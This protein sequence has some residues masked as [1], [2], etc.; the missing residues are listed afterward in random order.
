MESPVDSENITTPLWKILK[1]LRNTFSFLVTFFFLSF[2]LLFSQGWHFILLNKKIP[3]L[4]LTSTKYS[5][6]YNPEATSC[7]TC[8]SLLDKLCE[9]LQIC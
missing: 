1:Q 3:G 4:I 5:T 7:D 2:L 9:I 6:R 8:S